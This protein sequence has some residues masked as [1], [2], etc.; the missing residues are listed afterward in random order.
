LSPSQPP[1]PPPL[2][3]RGLPRGSR[4]DPG[5]EV[6]PRQTREALAR[7]DDD[8]PFLLDC[9]RTDEWALC[10]IE[11]AVLVPM[12]QVARRLDE[13]EDAAGSKDRPIIVYCHHGRRSLTVT[14]QLRAVGF[15]DVKSMAGGIDL[16]SMDIDAAVPRY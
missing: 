10:R 15:T 13:I 3:D 16:W 12:D 11:G 5:M 7:T 9:R 14:S 4:L 6:T 1:P 8:R 2:D